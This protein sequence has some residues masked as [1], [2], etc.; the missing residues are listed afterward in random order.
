M[1]PVKASPVAEL[2]FAQSGAVV[3]P[4]T[5]MAVTLDCCHVKD[6]DWHA[7]DRAAIG[8]RLADI[9]LATQYN[10]PYPY[11]SPKVFLLMNVRIIK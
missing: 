5:Y 3:V 11:K 10:K 4:Y 1:V 7:C 6:P 2:R 9:A 8:R